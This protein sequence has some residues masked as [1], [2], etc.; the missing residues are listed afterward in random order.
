M[1]VCDISQ[2]CSKFDVVF[3]THFLFPLNSERL[4]ITFP[5]FARKLLSNY[6]QNL[7]WQC[8][9]LRFENTR[10]LHCV[11]SVRI[12]SFSG[13]YF[14]AFA[15]NTEKYSVCLRIQ[16]DCGKIRIRKTPNMDTF[17][18]VLRTLILFFKKKKKW[19]SVMLRDIL[20]THSNI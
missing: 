11:K 18:T 10:T 1:L 13:L 3:A 20:R 17:H 2:I 15:L 19:K 9:L 14:P 6:F 8:F 12:R 7:I 5:C 16:S 4:S